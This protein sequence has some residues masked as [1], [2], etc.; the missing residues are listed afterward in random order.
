MI[1]QIENQTK[2]YLKMLV[3]RF[4][5]FGIQM[6]TVSRTIDKWM[7][8]V[9]WTLLNSSFLGLLFYHQRP[10]EV[11][12]PQ[13]M[14]SFKMIFFWLK[15]WQGINFRPFLIFSAIR[16]TCFLHKIFLILWCKHNIFWDGGLGVSLSEIK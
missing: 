10:R 7:V 14:I 3:F 1:I 2:K 15:I 12:I 9:I 6:L 4:W 8:Q 13:A 16:Q 5:V 11:A